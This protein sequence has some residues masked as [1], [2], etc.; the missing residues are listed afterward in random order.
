[1]KIVRYQFAELWQV[2]STPDT[3]SDDGLFIYGASKSSVD[4]SNGDIT[5]T[6]VKVWPDRETFVVAFREAGLVGGIAL[7][8]RPS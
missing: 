4:I 3:W 6:L 7:V 8:L 2:I 5:L 1:M